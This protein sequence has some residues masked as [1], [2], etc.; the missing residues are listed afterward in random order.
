MGE[1]T[2]KSEMLTP[3]GTPEAKAS[4]SGLE[5][6]TPMTT[7]TSKGDTSTPWSSCRTPS[8]TTTSCAVGLMQEPAVIAEATPLPMSCPA[9][10]EAETDLPSTWW[11]TFA[12]ANCPSDKEESPRHSDGPCSMRPCISLPT[13]VIKDTLPASAS[14]TPRE[15]PRWPD[16]TLLLTASTPKRTVVAVPSPRSLVATEL[17]VMQRPLIR[18]LEK[19]DPTAEGILVLVSAVALVLNLSQDLSVRAT[20]GSN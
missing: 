12:Y 15:T 18:L 19:E 9:E 1:L 4:E 11:L 17:V 3:A 6:G 14:G 2:P 20:A 13:P 8:R 10:A 7:R 5:D 16:S